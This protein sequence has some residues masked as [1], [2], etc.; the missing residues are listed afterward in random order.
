M[1]SDVYIATICWDGICELTQGERTFYRLTL[2]D[3]IEGAQQY[4]Y[5]FESRHPYLECASV[6]LRNG[7]NTVESK[8]LTET[9]K[10][11]IKTKENQK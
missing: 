11:I 5:T 2:E 4:L 3:L 6:E 1:K 8:D 10:L 9:V 7:V